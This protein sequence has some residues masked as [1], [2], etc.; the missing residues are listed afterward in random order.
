MRLQDLLP[1]QEVLLSLEPEELAHAVLKVLVAEGE[2][3]GLLNS[4]N[5][6]LN[7][8]LTG[9]QSYD[10]VAR[11][12]M[13]AWVWLEREGL[14][15]PRPGDSNNTWVFVIRIHLHSI[16]LVPGRGD[17]RRGLR[18]CIRSSANMD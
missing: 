5:F 17:I 14:I 8:N 2:R 12:V 4:Y 9:Y 16:R 11:A 15:A 18:M 7:G 13:E 3:G 6:T 10:R 1:D